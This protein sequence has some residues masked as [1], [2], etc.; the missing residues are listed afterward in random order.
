MQSPRQAFHSLVLTGFL[1]VDI[2]RNVNNT[3][4][5]LKACEPN[6]AQILAWILRYLHIAPNVAWA[7]RFNVGAHAIHEVLPGGK[8]SRRYIEYAFPGCSD[9]LGQMKD[10]RFL[11]IEVK[12]KNGRATD[13]QK[14][15]LQNVR[16][17]NGIAILARSVDD[18]VNELMKETDG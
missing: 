17:N 5:K 18:V 15:F 14:A 16:D 12:S 10:G 4:Y 8:Q 6:E 2:I 13:D 1:L 7:H 3:A 11:A 9:I